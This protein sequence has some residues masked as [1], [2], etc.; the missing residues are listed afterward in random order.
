MP[1]GGSPVAVSA[2]ATTRPLP[3]TPETSAGLSPASNCTVLPGFGTRLCTKNADGFFAKSN[4]CGHV[5]CGPAASASPPGAGGMRYSSGKVTGSISSSGV[6]PY[7]PRLY[8]HS[9]PSIDEAAALLHEFA[10]QLQPFRR[11]RRRVEIRDDD[12]GVARPL[13]A[14]RRVIEA[15]GRLKVGAARN[16]GVLVPQPRLVQRRLP[17]EV[18]APK[19]LDHERLR[20]ERGLPRPGFG[21]AGCRAEKG[22]RRDGGGAQDS[23]AQSHGASVWAFPRRSSPTRGLTPRLRALHS[24]AMSPQPAALLG[25]R[26]LRLA[27]ILAL[28]AV[29]ALFAWPGGLRR[30]SHAVSVS[31]RRHPRDLVRPASAGRRCRPGGAGGKHRAGGDR[32]AAQNPEHLRSGERDQPFQHEHRRGEMLARAAGCPR[33]LRC[34]ERE[35]GRGLQWPSRRSHRGVEGGRE[36]RRATGCRDAATHR[37]RRRPAGLEARPRRRHGHAPAR[38]T[39]R[40]RLARQGLH[41]REGRGR[42]AQPDA[43]GARVS[44]QHRRRYARERGVGAGRGMDRRGGQSHPERG[45]CA[46]AHAGAD[47]QSRDLHERGV[48][49]RL[50]HRGA[51]LL[52]HLRSAHG[53]ARRGHRQRDRAGAEH[54]DLERP[55][56][57]PLHPEAG[58]GSRPS[59][60]GS[61][62]RLPDRRRRRPA[63]SQPAFC[64]V[65]GAARDARP[66]RGREPRTGGRQPLAGGFRSDAQHQPETAAA[67]WKRRT[68]AALPRRV[69]GG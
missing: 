58:G 15:R 22:Q 19:P 49:A 50:H 11:E 38:R 47:Q 68:E 34:L 3:N 44:P 52:A 18:I 53:L 13:L 25:A 27:P 57:H 40:H 46:A 9:P 66:A 28:A 24:R 65:R 39:A 61:R 64:L 23:A 20:H 45:Q 7:A 6:P 54:G 37:A 59:P 4:G 63:I 56:H 10:N 2:H 33:L 60:A 36:S 67:G 69:G 55:R 8:A 5:A 16:E 17:A 62:C 26:S 43:G 29:L 14:R 41:H 42:R 51:A 1:A 35:I 21:G 48:R 12:D 32:A 31:S 30:R